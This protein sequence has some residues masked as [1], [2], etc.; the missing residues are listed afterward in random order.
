MACSPVQLAKRALVILLLTFARQYGMPAL[1]LSR[2]SPDKVVMDSFRKVAKK[3]HPD[4]GGSTEDTQKLNAAR[5]V[6]DN[7]PVAAR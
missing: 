4:K 6:W 3:A 2:D 5:E 7:V 1:P